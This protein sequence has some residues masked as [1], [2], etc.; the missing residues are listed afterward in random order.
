MTKW[1]IQVT[2]THVADAALFMIRFKLN[3]MFGSP[4]VSLQSRNQYWLPVASPLH[5]NAEAFG[6]ASCMSISLVRVWRI[7]MF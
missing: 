4:R 1:R 2:V 6:A 5:Y 3:L 7:P